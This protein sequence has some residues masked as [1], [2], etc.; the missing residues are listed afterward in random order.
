VKLDFERRTL[1]FAHPLETPYGLLEQRELL[2]VSLTDEDGISGHGEAA[3]LEPYDGIS[4]ERTQAA[5]ESY[6]PL[7]ADAS[8]LNG[9]QLLDAC[10]RVD[11]LPQALA[12][13]DLALWDRGGRLAGKPIAEL[14]TDDPAA[15]V[16]V[17]ATIAAG[18]RAGVAEQVTAALTAGYECVKLK[19]GIGDDAGRVAAA[20]AAG[21]PQMTLRVDANGVWDVDG[22]VRTIEALA[23]AGLELVEE[24]VH[25]LQRV[26][27]VRERVPVRVAIDETAAEHGALT[28][29]VADAVCLKISRCGGIG[30]LIAAA[31]LVRASGAEVYV[32]STYDGPLGI[33]AGVHVAAAL[34]SRG[35]VPH[36]GLATLGLFE[37]IEDPLPARDGEIE[38]PRGPGLGVTPI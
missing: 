18:D 27:Q 37:G 3:P 28:A 29:G 5:L 34:A 25:G 15:T 16:P 2:T 26:R 30:G 23:P 19:V 14:L 21:G 1:R 12:A 17:N 10:R 31:A 24:P 35:P 4:I 22:A 20:R 38:V 7:L 11:E 36:C 9:A 6:A 33:A 8:G 32:A 13:I